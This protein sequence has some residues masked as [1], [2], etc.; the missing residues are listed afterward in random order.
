MAL[1]F[2]FLMGLLVVVAHREMGGALPGE[3]TV[4]NLSLIHI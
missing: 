1:P 2:S 4:V 3:G